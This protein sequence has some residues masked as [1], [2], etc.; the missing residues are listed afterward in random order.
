MGPYTALFLIRKGVF[1]FGCCVP[2]PYRSKLSSGRHPFGVRSSISNAD[3]RTAKLMIISCFAKWR[4]GH[5]CSPKPNGIHCPCRPFSENFGDCSPSTCGSFT[6]KRS[7]WKVVKGCSPS[8]LSH[9][10]L[11]C[12]TCDEMMRPW[13]LGKSHFPMLCS[14]FA[15][16]VMRVITCRRKVSAYIDCSKSLFVSFAGSNVFSRTA[17]GPP[18]VLASSFLVR[19][20]RPSDARTSNKYQK[21]AGMTFVVKLLRS[22][23]VVMSLQSI[24]LRPY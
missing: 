14:F 8:L 9:C 7:G 19:L 22:V 17:F 3:T 1:C 15:V 13:S 10:A 11:R 24:D 5:M 12:S 16:L 2:N 18:S 6:R 23:L 4:P 21:E 20:R